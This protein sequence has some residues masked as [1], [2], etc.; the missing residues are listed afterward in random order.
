MYFYI[1]FLRDIVSNARSNETLFQRQL[2]AVD[3]FMRQQGLN[4]ERRRRILRRMRF[5]WEQQKSLN[6]SQILDI[7]PIK[8][9]CTWHTKDTPSLK[10]L[11]SWLPDGLFC[12]NA[13]KAMNGYS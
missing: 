12:G 1:L 2:V 3:G 4:K 8:I 10:Y 11:E 13:F 6:E 7:L 5:T 9:R